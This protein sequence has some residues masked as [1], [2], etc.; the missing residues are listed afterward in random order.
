VAAALPARRTKMPLRLLRALVVHRRLVACLCV[1][2]LIA[3]AAV[4]WFVG[5]SLVAPNRFE[6][7]EP[8]AQPPN[9]EVAFASAS[10][11]RL[12]GWY[13]E[14]EDAQAA[15]LL[16]HGLR[17]SRRQMAERAQLLHAAGFATLA[18]DLQGHGESE[19]DAITAGWRERDDVRAAVQW[20]KERQPAR[21][22]GV[23]GISLGGA[24]TLL[25]GPRADGREAASAPLAIDA[26]VL[27][28][29]YPT[30]DE[31]VHAR[32]DAEL[33]PLA[34]LLTPALLTQ[35][36]LRL[37]IDTALVRPID[38]IAACGAP[39]LFLAGN[40]DLGT[41]LPQSLRLFETARDPK[42]LV[43]FEGAGHVDLC[44]HDR[45]LWEREVLAFLGA[46]LSEP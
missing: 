11:A 23:I 26:L 35:F 24:A 10:G 28:S 2:G 40:Q 33:G 21:R 32:I 8:P 14:H 15:V 4:V 16:L 42:T 37:S 44:R 43:V 39:V 22:L 31:A 25:A 46:H 3:F 41:P 34:H 1:A 38:H 6:V 13:A 36:E 20:L 19:G 17:A 12:A 7:G 27:E 29:V 18:I 30:I 9:E 5:G 45:A